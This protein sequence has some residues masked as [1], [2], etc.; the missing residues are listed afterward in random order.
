MS[1]SP[2]KL[3]QDLLQLLPALLGLP[4]VPPPTP[5]V[6]EC[7]GLSRTCIGDQRFE[8]ELRER[9]SW[10]RCNCIGYTEIS[11]IYEPEYGLTGRRFAFEDPD[12]AVVFKLTFAV[13][14]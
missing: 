6:V 2:P 9:T 8:V 7:W 11:G 13:R 14:L 10:I 12:E 4:V 3:S 1:K 5:H